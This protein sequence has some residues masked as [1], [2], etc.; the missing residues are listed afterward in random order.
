[1]THVTCRLTA[2]NRDQL[3]NPTLGN[4]VWATF[5]FL[6]LHNSAVPLCACWA[7]ERALRKRLN[8]SRY[9]LACGL[10]GVPRNHI[11]S[12]SPNS[13]P[14][15]RDTFWGRGNTWACSDIFNLIRK[16]AAA[17]R[18]LATGTIATCFFNSNFAICWYK[19]LRWTCN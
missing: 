5:A 12:G 13:P 7:R 16:L 19:A 15:Y 10:P 9:R 6:L 3:R 18:P 1:M 2:K 8:R 14:A 4:R 17:M 11:L